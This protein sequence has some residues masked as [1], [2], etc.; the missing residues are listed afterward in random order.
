MKAKKAKL[1]AICVLSLLLV[2]VSA[3]SNSGSPSNGS[4]NNGNSGA[5]NNGDTGTDTGNKDDGEVIDPMGKIDPPVEITAIRPLDSTTKFAEGESI[6]NNAW[7]RLYEQEFGIKLKYLWVADTSQYDQKFNVAMV[8]GKLAD[9]MP[10]NAIQFQQLVDADQLEDLSEALEKYGTEKSKLLLE[11]DGGVGLDSA[12]FNGKLL[13]LP[14]AS[15]YTDNAPLLW[16]R[17]DWL[18]KLGLPEPKTMD[19]VLAIADAFV[20]QDPDNNGQ[21][22]TYGL[23]VE[24][25]FY[26]AVPGLQGFF[27]SYHAYPE[28]WVKDDEGKLVYGSIQP[29]MK[30]ALA[31][32]QQMY[33]D[34][35]IDREFGV[36]DAEKIF[37]AVNSGKMGMFYGLMYAP[38]LFQDGKT[39]DPNMDWKAFPLPS[40]DGEVA[41]PQTP[42]TVGRYYVVRKGVKNPEAAVKML[43]AFHYGW[44][45]KYPP[46]EITQDGDIEK[47]HYALVTGSNPT[48]NL[49]MYVKVTEGLEKNDT[50]GFDAPGQN[51]F[52]DS[53]V[54]FREGD[55]SGWGYTRVYDA[56][57]LL[58]EYN[59]NNGYQMTEYI[60]GPTP[61]MVEKDSTL[62][63]MELETFTKIVMGEASI[64]EFDDF[65]SDWKKLGGDVITEEVAAWHKSKNGN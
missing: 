29:E 31:K 57:K 2:I 22:D 28:I 65:V 8:S 11:K 5:V 55:M 30:E 17:T 44:E 56:Q 52:Y 18:E 38:L 61:T 34:G 43:N 51:V 53:I 35:L 7:N 14:L 49:D 62:K 63:K 12:T 24:K 42:F 20:N 13:G 4:T 3:C 26:G 39:N 9:I 23:G 32:L 60:A 59:Q 47:W 54:K 16:V 45:D 50:S 37:Q 41:K 1:V 27:N 10:V 36:K 40:I 64:D 33:K 6:E 21:K 58:Y 48:Q 19:D 46:T 25:L 15:S